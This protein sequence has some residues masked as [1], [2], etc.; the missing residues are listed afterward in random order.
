[1]HKQEGQ[2]TMKQM[3]VSGNDIM[4]QFKL[5]AWPRVGELL[6]IAMDRVIDD[7]KDRNTKEKIFCYLAPKAK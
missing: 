4:K 3:A 2:F 7:I 6:E 1:L 5:K